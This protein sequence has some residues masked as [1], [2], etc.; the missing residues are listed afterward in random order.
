M[1]NLSSRIRD[2]DDVEIAFLKLKSSNPTKANQLLSEQIQRREKDLAL[3]IDEA[4]N[5]HQL[6]LKLE[7]LYQGVVKPE[8][9]ANK[10]VE[11]AVTPRMTVHM[12]DPLYK[13]S[14][15]QVVNYV[16]SDAFP[17]TRKGR[18]F[19][20]RHGIIGLSWRTKRPEY[21]PEVSDNPDDL[22]KKWGMTETEA[23]KA[24]L[25]RKSHLALPFPLSSKKRVKFIFFFDA[26][27]VHI[28]G[29]DDLHRKEEIIQKIYNGIASEGLDA[30]L[31]QLFSEF[32]QEKP[33]IDF[34]HGP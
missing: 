24:G 20:T 34:T 15:F 25:G 14:L 33:I 22:I 1:R 26:Q 32:E 31:E 18:R 3:R 2:A 10:L 17:E 9:N 16:P 5:R 23:Q 27:P 4:A 29:D 7:S 6:Q 19:S 11:E 28:F 21:D 12:S 30:V 13:D 8:I